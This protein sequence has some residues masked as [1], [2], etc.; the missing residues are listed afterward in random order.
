[1]TKKTLTKVIIERARLFKELN[2]D[3]LTTDEVITKRAKRLGELTNRVGCAREVVKEILEL[4]TGESIPVGSSAYFKA[5][6]L[7]VVVPTENKNTHTYTIGKVA[8]LKDSGFSYVIQNEGGAG[9]T[10]GSNAGSLRPATNDEI[11]ERVKRLTDS[12]IA[13]LIDQVIV[14]EI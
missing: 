7:A 5:V 8:I 6:A 10:L 14:V 1:M 11:I 12:D 4:V 9:N 13:Q 2:K 3:L